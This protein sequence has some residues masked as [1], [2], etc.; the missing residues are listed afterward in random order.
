MAVTLA[1]VVGVYLSLGVAR[2]ILATPPTCS[3]LDGLWYLDQLVPRG[4]RLVFVRS[5]PDVESGRLFFCTQYSIAPRVVAM[6]YRSAVATYLTPGTS[7]LM[8]KDDASSSQEIVIELTALADAQG[9]IIEWR[10]LTERLLLA[11]V[12]RREA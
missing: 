11:M 8:Y 7:L 5:S 4:A 2:S 3:G 1:W 6:G 10:R 12:S 9:L